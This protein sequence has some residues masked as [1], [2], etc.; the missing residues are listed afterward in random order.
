MQELSYDEI[1]NVAGAGIIKNIIDFCA[2]FAEGFS[3]GMDYI[4][5]SGGMDG[6]SLPNGE[7]LGT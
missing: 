5:H 7:S 3:Q 2:G 1:E 6:W 4:N